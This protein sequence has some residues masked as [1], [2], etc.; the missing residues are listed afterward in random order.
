MVAY[1][2]EPILQQ[3]EKT[4]RT[5]ALET[6]SRN[7]FRNQAQKTTVNPTR[8]MTADK[9]RLHKVPMIGSM[10]LFHY[11]PKMKQ[12]LPYYDIFPLVIPFDSAKTSGIAGSGGP[13]FYG[14]NLH[15]LPALLRAKLMDGLY[16]YITDKNLNENTRIR[17]SYKILKKTASLKYFRPCVKQYLFN[18]VRSKF[19][20]IA[21]NEWDIAL[22]LN[23]A[24]F[25]KATIE[26]VHRDSKGKIY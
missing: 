2:F 24:R 11:D 22:F 10:Y 15:Y 4:G 6:N 18:H 23:L 5:S 16:Q 13:S 20:Y 1:V 25:Q 21:P 26:Q 19:F 17:M 14:L 9:N 12:E 3:G 7:W 8:L